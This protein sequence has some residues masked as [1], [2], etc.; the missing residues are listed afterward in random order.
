M[1]VDQMVTVMVVL[2]AQD[3]QEMAVKEV[4]VAMAV[5]VVMVQMVPQP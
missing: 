4:L 3:V 1:A 2:L 5:A